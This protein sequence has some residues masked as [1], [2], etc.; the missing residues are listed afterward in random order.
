LTA[1]SHHFFEVMMLIRAGHSTHHAQL[2]Q[3]QRPQ[4]QPPMVY[5][6]EKQLWEY[7][8]VVRNVA[9]DELV[10]EQELNTLGRSGWEL[11]GVVR[12]PSKVQFYFKRIRK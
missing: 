8:I 5:V 10:S 4:V 11:A 12:L 9:A 7:K 1:V 6:Y 2:Q 3:P